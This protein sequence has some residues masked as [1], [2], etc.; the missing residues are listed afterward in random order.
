MKKSDILKFLGEAATI[1]TE[2]AVETVRSKPYGIVH[3]SHEI[4]MCGKKGLLVWDY[5]LYNELTFEEIDTQIK[6]S[7][8]TSV[9]DE[10]TKAR[11]E[12]LVE[13]YGQ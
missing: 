9:S 4:V 10:E 7:L 8:F 6:H 1:I 12:L 5:I 3:D 13:E 11:F 2:V